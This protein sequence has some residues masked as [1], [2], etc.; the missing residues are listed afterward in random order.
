[1]AEV[2]LAVLYSF[3]LVRALAV[4]TEKPN[5]GQFENWVAPPYYSAMFN[6]RGDPSCKV[7]RGNSGQRV[8]PV[9]RSYA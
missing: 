3:V 4:A 9:T 6:T 2:A 8:I 5:I 1:M 7:K